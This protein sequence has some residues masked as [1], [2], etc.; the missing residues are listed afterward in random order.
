MHTH[1]HRKQELDR[2]FFSHSVWTNVQSFFNNRNMPLIHELIW[3]LILPWMPY[4]G[5]LLSY[6]C[7]IPILIWPSISTELNQIFKTLEGLF[8]RISLFWSYMIILNF[9]MV[10]HWLLYIPFPSPLLL[11]LIECVTACESAGDWKPACPFIESHWGEGPTMVP[12]I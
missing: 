12:N 5:I 6:S 11:H 3:R 2:S 4:R 9:R 10:A 8:C 7:H 1:A